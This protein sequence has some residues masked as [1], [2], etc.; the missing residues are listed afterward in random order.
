MA[1]CRQ[2]WTL[3]GSEGEIIDKYEIKDSSTPIEN[4]FRGAELTL[5][6]SHMGSGTFDY[7]TREYKLAGSVEK[8]IKV[9]YN[10]FHVCEYTYRYE[11]LEG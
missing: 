10:G 5:Y 11:E 2:S 9:T 6:K 1:N 7:D 8:I 4:P 3:T